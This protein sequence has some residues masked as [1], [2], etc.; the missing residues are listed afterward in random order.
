MR[1]V[2]KGAGGGLTAFAGVDPV[3]M[4]TGRALQSR[5]RLFVF[6]TARIGLSR[7]KAEAVITLLKAK[8]GAT[9]TELMQATGWQAHSVRGAIA[10]AIKKRFGLVVISEKVDGERVYR[11]AAGV[12]E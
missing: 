2:G 6:G 10:G 7:T 12:S 1:R 4:M 9:I 11:I 3:E 8:R 5:L